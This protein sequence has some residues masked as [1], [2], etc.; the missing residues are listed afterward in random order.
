[1]CS[2]LM[3]GMMMVLTFTDD[4]ARLEPHERVDLPARSSAAASSPRNGRL[5]SR[6]Q[7]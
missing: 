4:A 2:S 6:T 3:P 1:M 5:P 7:A